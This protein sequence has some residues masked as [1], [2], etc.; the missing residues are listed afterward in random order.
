MCPLADSR[1]MIKEAKDFP[2]YAKAMIKAI[3]KFRKKKAHLAFVQSFTDE[4]EMFYLFLLQKMNKK[5]KEQISNNIF[6]FDAKKQLEKN[7]KINL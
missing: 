4:Y 2:R 7:L 5:G 3:A 1:Q 6:Q